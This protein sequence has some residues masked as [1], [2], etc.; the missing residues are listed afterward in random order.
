MVRTKRIE[1]CLSRSTG[2]E[3]RWLLL[4]LLAA[5]AILLLLGQSMPVQAGNPEPQYVTSSNGADTDCDQAHELF[6][7]HCHVT[8]A[9]SAYAQIETSPATFDEMT[10]AHPLPMAEGAR[11]TQSPRPNL[12]PP[13]H[14]G[15]A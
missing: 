5:V 4:C 15:Q 9:C 12:Q 10:S 13:K 7:G 6:G 11:V 3:W 8:V 14:F 2:V 1:Q